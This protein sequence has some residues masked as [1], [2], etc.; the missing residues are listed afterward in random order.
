MVAHLLSTP[1]LLGIISALFGA[2][3]C[4]LAKVVLR[5]APVHDYLSLN[6]TIIFVLLLPLAPF[7]FRA[8]AHMGRLGIA[9]PIRYTGYC[10]Q[11]FLLSR[12]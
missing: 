5:Y 8:P 3:S 10:G 1:L 4:I 7:A 2:C 9:H 6:F 12:L 11:L